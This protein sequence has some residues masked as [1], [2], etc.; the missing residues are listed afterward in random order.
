MTGVAAM[1]WNGVQRSPR[2]AGQEVV[3]MSTEEVCGGN[4]PS[5]TA[6]AE[7]SNSTLI[8]DR[9]HAMTDSIQGRMAR[10]AAWMV[11]FKLVERSLGLISTLILARLLV[12]GD[13]GVVAMAMSFVLMAE[14]LTAFGFDVAIIQNQNATEEHYSTAWTGNLLLGVGIT[15]LMLVAAWPIASFYGRPELALV[16]CALALGPLFSGAENIGIVA[17]RKE[18]DFRREFKFQITRKLIAFAVVV[19]MALVFRNYWALVAGTLVSKLGSTVI[20]YLMHPFRPRFTLVQIKPMMHFSRWLLF[21]NA[22]S[23]LKERS[24]DFFIGRFHG[25]PALGL[26]NIAYE[27]A[28]LPTTELGAPINRALVP[29]FAKLS[30][31]EDIRAAYRNA[32][33]MLATVAL[34]AAAGIF[35]VAPL[36]VPVVFGPKWLAAVPLMQLL[37]FNGAL[38]LFHSSI[39]AVLVARGH[40]ARVTRVNA[41]YVLVL[42]CGLAV[43]S[44]LGG[45]E[46]AA[47]AALATSFACTPIYLYE[48]KRSLGVAPGVFVSALVRPVVASGAMLATLLFVLPGR[49]HGLPLPAAVF[50]LGLG[51]GLGAVVYLAVLLIAWIAAGKPD[52]PEQMLADRLRAR[53]A[54]AAPPVQGSHH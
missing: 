4:R 14:L 54:R 24:S 7:C 10:G 2:Q 41:I 33:A 35:A 38:L 13:F 21:N 49:D 28:H 50:W 31:A 20:S 16:V 6:G 8:I 9:R 12:P 44:Q 26:Y 18:L 37:C 25:A 32:V 5:A 19:P 53:L 1:S 30:L 47:V 42:L 11:L 34:P 22:V 23:F 3:V 52:G 36:L 17:F 45:V 43:G 48:M 29:G 40:P 15:V 51:I 46:W 27:F 39:C